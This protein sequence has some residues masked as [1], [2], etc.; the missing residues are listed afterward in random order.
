MA[1]HVYDIISLFTGFDLYLVVCSSDK[2]RELP[3]GAIYRCTHIVHLDSTGVS[4]RGQCVVDF[5]KCWEVAGG[6]HRQRAMII[7]KDLF[8]LGEQDYLRLPRDER[9]K[10]MAP[11]P[12]PSP[13]E[14]PNTP[15]MELRSR[16]V[17]FFKL[18]LRMISLSGSRD[19]M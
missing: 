15:T 16:Y 6:P 11:A 18:E 10:D 17:P 7:S 1:I 3:A 4:I 5:M 8:L 13:P 14:T 2:V 12:S 19:I 9:R